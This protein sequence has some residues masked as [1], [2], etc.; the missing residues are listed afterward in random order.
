MWISKGKVL[1][2]NPNSI[3]FDKIQSIQ[4]FHIFI[5]ILHLVESLSLQLR[6][7]RRP[8]PLSE[9]VQRHV[10]TCNVN[11]ENTTCDVW[12]HGPPNK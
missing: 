10:P 3:C 5:Y 1:T 9:P 11:P 8:V 4:L 7:H 2:S 6:P 12:D